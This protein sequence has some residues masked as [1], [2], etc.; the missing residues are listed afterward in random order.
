MPVPEMLSPILVN[1]SHKV[2]SK[3]RRNSEAGEMKRV[4]IL[5]FWSQFPIVNFE[6]IGRSIKQGDKLT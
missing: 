3:I 4:S 1:S 2:G 5:I 6:V